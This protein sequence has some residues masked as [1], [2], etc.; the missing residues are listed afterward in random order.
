MNAFIETDGRSQGGLEASVIDDV[1]VRQGLL[2]QEK[3][4]LVERLEGGQVVEGVG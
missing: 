2:D 3:V 1:V 4:K